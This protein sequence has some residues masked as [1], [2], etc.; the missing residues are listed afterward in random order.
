M[1]VG[2]HNTAD[3]ARRIRDLKLVI[4]GLLAA[5]ILL[6]SLTVY[7]WISPSRTRQPAEPKFVRLLSSQDMSNLIGG[8]WSPQKSGSFNASNP[9]GTSQTEVI[10]R[11]EPS[12]IFASVGVSGF[13]STAQSSFAY[14][15]Y[16]LGFLESANSTQRGTYPTGTNY[17]VFSN[18]YRGAACSSVAVIAVQS[19][20]VIRISLGTD[21]SMPSR[22][23]SSTSILSLLRVQLSD[24][25]GFSITT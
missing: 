17:T 2:A 9:T 16:Q 8:D 4:A 22:D 3:G 10:V 19:L 25:P 7:L 23:I 1:E 13:N 24:I 18:C 20:Y 12:F 11:L 6:S 14:V 15:N 21:L 5:I